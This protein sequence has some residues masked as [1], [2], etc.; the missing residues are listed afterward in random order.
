MN[1]GMEQPKRGVGSRAP[2]ESAPKS[3]ETPFD[4]WAEQ[5]KGLVDR[6]DHSPQ[7]E[8]T[9]P[10]VAFSQ[11]LLKLLEAKSSGEL[12][13]LFD[14]LQHDL[15]NHDFLTFGNRIIMA[16]DT[17]V[18]E[19]GKNFNEFASVLSKLPI[20]MY[21]KSLIQKRNELVQSFSNRASQLLGT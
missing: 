19:L 15:T 5:A 9:E 12:S 4:H 10:G 1:F 6:I 16:H 2:M 11:D 18:S 17:S 8:E 14:T 13:S 20:P 21:D 3:A 7:L